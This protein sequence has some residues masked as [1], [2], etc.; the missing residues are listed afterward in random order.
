MQAFGQVYLKSIP[1]FLY[2]LDETG[3]WQR[4]PVRTTC[5]LLWY[6]SDVQL[7][8]SAIGF[9]STSK[10]HNRHHAILV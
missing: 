4:N 8:K 5:L 2:T 9:G 1:P 10:P 7:Q 6:K 3:Q